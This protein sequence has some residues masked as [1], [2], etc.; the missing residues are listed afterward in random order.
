MLLL[1]AGYILV[2]ATSLLASRRLVL[3]AFSLLAVLIGN[4]AMYALSGAH[5]AS[6]A[7]MVLYV[8]GVMVLVAYSLF[9]YPE[10]PERPRLIKVRQHLGKA[11]IL[12]GLAAAL[13]SFGPW[14]QLNRWASKQPV[15]AKL[16]LGYPQIG[17]TFLNKYIL[18]YELIG[19]L[20]LA[21]IVVG[22]WFLRFH[23]FSKN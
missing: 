11:L 5:I 4:S 12:I 20:L 9:L 13:V 16:L 8:G 23:D 6:V 7:Q 15:H 1:L 10:T 17:Q 18:E 2:A 22:G 14:E 3:G 21:G 19:V